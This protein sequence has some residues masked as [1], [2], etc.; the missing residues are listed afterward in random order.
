MKETTRQLVL[1][2]GILSLLTSSYIV[3]TVSGD[4]PNSGDNMSQVEDNINEQNKTIQNNTG[5]NSNFTDSSNEEEP[6]GLIGKSIR[7]F[8]IL[9]EDIGRAMQLLWSTES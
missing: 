3:V 8:K 9:I 1:L 4:D 7:G 5:Q 6:E 2:F